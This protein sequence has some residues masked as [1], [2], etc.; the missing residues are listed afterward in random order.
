M[1][2]WLTDTARA[3]VFQ[4]DADPREF[5]KVAE[6]AGLAVFRVDIAHA[7]G[8]ADFLACI[9]QSLR[10]PPDFGSN[11]DALLDCLRDLSWLEAP[12][13]VVILDRS[14]HFCAGH[15]QEFAQ[16]MEIM[17]EA[18]DFWRQEGRPLWT[19]VSGPQGWR[20]GWPEMP[21]G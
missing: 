15:P 12:G 9:A 14:K 13:W 18:A 5:T 16:A 3:G 7:H 19:L 20:S 4:L 10:F 11:W 6:A 21:A 8:K 2:H 17:G 1:T